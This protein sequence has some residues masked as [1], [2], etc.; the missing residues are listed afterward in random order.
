[1]RRECRGAV[2]RNYVLCRCG[3]RYEKIKR[4]CPSC[5]KAKPKRRRP[6]HEKALDNDY[7]FF[8]EFNERVHGPAF[9]PEWS[10]DDCG[11]CGKKPTDITVRKHDRDHGHRKEEHSY[12]KAR[13]LACPGNSG[14]NMKMKGFTAKELRQM[15]DYMERAE[16]ANTKPEGQWHTK[17][18]ATS[19]PSQP[20][21]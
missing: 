8:R 16:R 3:Y 1:M 18:S 19:A 14:C 10:P 6:E 4:K 12:A 5:A 15:A 11:C 9:G 2:A 7:G 13:G 20:G 21:S 17:D